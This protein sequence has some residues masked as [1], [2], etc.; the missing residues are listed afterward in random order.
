MQGVR[1]V[2]QS[3]MVLINLDEMVRHYGQRVSG[4]WG[5]SDPEKDMTE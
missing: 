2:V 4:R 5:K 3:L 1:T